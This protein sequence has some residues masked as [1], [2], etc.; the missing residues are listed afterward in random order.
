[1]RA[2]AAHPFQEA[3]IIMELRAGLKFFQPKPRHETPGEQAVFILLLNQASPLFSPV[4]EAAGKRGIVTSPT[5][6]LIHKS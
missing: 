5:R 1:M 3:W 2:A 4:T 6:P